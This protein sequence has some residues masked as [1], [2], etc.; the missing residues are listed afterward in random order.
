MKTIS[1]SF[2]DLGNSMALFYIST[3][4]ENVAV[5]EDLGLIAQGVDDGLR[6]GNLK[7]VIRMLRS[8]HADNPNLLPPHIKPELLNK[9]LTVKI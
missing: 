5:N 1:T 9:I 7:S 3:E 4:L 2:P 8:V 6:K